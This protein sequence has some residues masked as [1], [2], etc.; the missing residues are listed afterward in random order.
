M[1]IQNNFSGG[2]SCQQF[3]PI[4]DQLPGSIP[5]AITSKA[6][7]LGAS[8]SSYSSSIV[9]PPVISQASQVAFILEH[10]DNRTYA[11]CQN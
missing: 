9:Q 11:N 10:Y 3:Q 7:S 8:T 5:A 2:G 1:V 4:A 6:G